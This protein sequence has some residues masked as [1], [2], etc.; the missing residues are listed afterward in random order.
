MQ[1]IS[2]YIYRHNFGL[3]NMLAYPSGLYQYVF[4]T[5]FFQWQHIYFAYK[6]K[7]YYCM[8]QGLVLFTTS[9]TYWWN[10][11][12]NCLRRTIDMYVA[13][14]TIAFHAYLAIAH[15]TNPVLCGSTIALGAAMYPLSNW[16]VSNKWLI[17]R[18]LNQ[19][20]GTACHCL[21]HIIVS[22]GASLTYAHM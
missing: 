12:T 6:Y 17:K 16:C 22:I 13:H 2:I 1:V 10:P 19:A 9:V 7:K 4:A 3:Q 5:S 8:T 14:S 11:L 18:G 21:L 15:T 20:A